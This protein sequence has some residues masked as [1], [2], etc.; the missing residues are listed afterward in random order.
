MTM[1]TLNSV[2]KTPEE[3][4]QYL[5]KGAEARIDTSLNVSL[6]NVLQ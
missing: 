4:Y 6:E 2:E 1:S 3:E 5:S